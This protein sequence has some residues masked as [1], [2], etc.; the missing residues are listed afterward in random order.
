ME[1]FLKNGN[2]QNIVIK[3]K[4][5]DKMIYMN[6]MFEGIKTLYSIKDINNL[7][8]NKAINMNL[9]FYEC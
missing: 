2:G 8:L 1:E 4:L 5:L 3:L 6:S 9:F 7:N